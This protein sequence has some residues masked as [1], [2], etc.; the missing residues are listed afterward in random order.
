[1]RAKNLTLAAVAGGAAVL[2][3]AVVCLTGGRADAASRGSSSRKGA[4]P[5]S[6]TAAPRAR[7]AY[8]ARAGGD[9][10]DG[11]ALPDRG[12][13]ADGAVLAKA[14]DLLGRLQAAV[15][16]T[17]EL[18][19]DLR[20][21]LMDFLDGGEE[22]RTALFSLA[23][24]PSSSRMLLGH[25]KVFLMGIRDEESR[26]V[27]LAAFEAFDP[28][29]AE[30]AAV[31]ARA[32]DP[33]LFV[34]SLRAAGT[35]KE[36]VDLMRKIP[37]ESWSEPTIAA[38]LLESASRDPDEDVRGNAYM[39]LALG[40]NA[41]SLP[42]IAAAA[43]DPARSVKER[44]RAAF[45]LA[46][47]PVKPSVDEMLRLY[48]TSPDEVRRN[49]LAAVAGTP[50]DRRI[51]DLLLEA[52]A[53]GETTDKTRKAAASAIQ[54]RLERLPAADARDLGARTAEIVKALDSEKAVLALN[55]LGGAVCVNEPLKE[56]VKELERTAPAGG[57]IQVALVNIPALRFA[58]GRN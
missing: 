48:E 19:A 58:L 23:W 25:L 45:A 55:S 43:G 37:R 32:K 46:E 38:W 44:Q 27:L 21:D 53:A 16:P 30:R 47:L 34:A 18:P 6:R 40:G 33:A 17:T 5:Q 13:A 56:A 20:R 1:M 3:V 50:A 24:D 7:A 51:D 41:G 52:L 57:A 22:N 31:A 10:T 14:R 29:A 2:V 28:H 42:V 36:R 39:L 12:A 11:R 4:A 26:R 49:L 9:R 15:G 35:A 54:S 8:A